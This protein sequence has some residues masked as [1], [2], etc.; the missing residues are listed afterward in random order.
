[1]KKMISLLLA[2]TMLMGLAA[3]GNQNKAEDTTAAPVDAPGSALEILEA[4]WA[5]YTAEEKFSVVGG[6]ADNLVMEAPGSYSVDDEGISA[7]LLVPTEETGKIDAAASIM[8]AMMSNY[9]TCGVFHVANS[10]DAEAFAKTMRDSIA[11][12]RWLCAMPETLFV[13]VVGGEYV[14]AAFGLD[15]NMKV[16]ET[17]LTT[18]YPAT[19]VKYSEAITG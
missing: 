6:D 18:A 1:M 7:I 17:K 14:V 15:D 16:F 19:D 4:V 8:H 10:A 11:S 13:A 12:N 3:C 9:F 2:L 5:S